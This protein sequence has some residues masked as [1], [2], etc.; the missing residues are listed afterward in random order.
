MSALITERDYD[1]AIFQAQ[2]EADAL[3]ERFMQEFKGPRRLA[4]VQ[5][6]PRAPQPKLPDPMKGGQTPMGGTGP[7]GNPPTGY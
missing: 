1:L 2:E 6:Q 5:A 4:H 3:Y 7:V